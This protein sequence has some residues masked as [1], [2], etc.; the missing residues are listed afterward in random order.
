MCLGPTDGTMTGLGQQ[1]AGGP[2][3]RM[4]EHINNGKGAQEGP[5]HCFL[6]MG[7]VSITLSK[8]A[9]SLR[10]SVLI[11]KMVIIMVPAYRSTEGDKCHNAQ[12]AWTPQALPY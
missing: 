9:T 4:R 10:F 1:K 6:A 2:A 8:L 7:V 11:P 3:Q 5:Q 12:K